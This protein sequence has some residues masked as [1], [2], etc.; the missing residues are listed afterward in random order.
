MVGQGHFQCR[1]EKPHILLYDIPDGET[2]ESVSE[3]TPCRECGAKIDWS[4]EF[5]G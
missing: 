2:I 3:K 4:Q 5:N 1:G